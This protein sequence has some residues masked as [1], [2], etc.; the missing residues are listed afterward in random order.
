MKYLTAALATTLAFAWTADAFAASKSRK[1]QQTYD[2]RQYES[3]RSSTTASNGLCQRDT[4]T[5][6][7][8]LNFRNRCDTLEFWERMNRNNTGTR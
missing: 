8:Q 3:R 5:P 7:S 2:S 4:G 6:N 1:R